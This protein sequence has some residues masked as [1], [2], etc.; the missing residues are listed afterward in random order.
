MLAPEPRLINKIHWH[1][2]QFV[3]FTVHPGETKAH[4]GRGHDKQI[5]IRGGRIITPCN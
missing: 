4:L 1:T 2:E 3:E 5:N